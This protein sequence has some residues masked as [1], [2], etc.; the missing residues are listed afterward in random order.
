MKTSRNTKL[1]VLGMTIALGG[2]GVAGFVLSE[3][4]PSGA[5]ATPAGSSSNAGTP[6]GDHAGTRLTEV[7]QP[8]VDDGTLTQAQLDAVIAKLESARPAHPGRGGHRPG[9]AY[10][11]TV[12]T[13]LGMSVADLRTALQ[14]D[15]ASIASVAAAKGV[16]EQD[17]INALVAE[18]KAQIEARITDGKITEEQAQ[19]RLST[20]TEEITKLVE[21]PAQN[22]R[23]H[24]WP[25]RHQR[26]GDSG[27][28]EA[29][30]TTP[31]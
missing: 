28:S 27:T 7:L 10:L 20:L 21:T 26:A 6:A 16:A 12:A 4:S 30:T 9:R 3:P 1:A 22:L 29:P 11:Q 5:L 17:V 8:L 19:A 14:A 13:T 2:G 18:R 15:G 31:G 25:G 23:G 24:G